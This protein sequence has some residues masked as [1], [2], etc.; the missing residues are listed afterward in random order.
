MFC[1]CVRVL[2]SAIV[3]HNYLPCVVQLHE[4]A[5]GPKAAA[6]SGLFGG[7]FLA[8]I[9]GLNLGLQKYF[10][11]NSQMQQV[12]FARYL[13][14]QSIVTNLPDAAV[15]EQMRVMR[16][17]QERMQAEGIP[18]PEPTWWQKMI[19]PDQMQ[20]PQQQQPAQ[21]STDFDDE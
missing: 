4:P 16:E 19:A 14:D 11:P 13:S 8:V 12:S 10:S 20:Q 21:F 2:L 3:Q 5:L 15:Q 17:A 9:E 18:P 6:M 7:V 1:F